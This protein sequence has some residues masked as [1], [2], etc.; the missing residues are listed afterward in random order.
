VVLF[1]AARERRLWLGVGVY[2]VA[3]YSTLG[4]MPQ[5]MNW[6]RSRGLLG[7]L[8]YVALG[9][10]IA[11]AAFSLR[12]LGPRALTA[13]AAA[14]LGYALWMRSQSIVQERLHLFEYG[15]LAVLLRSAL[16]ER[17]RDRKHPRAWRDGAA[18]LLAGAAGW[19]DEGIQYFLPNRVYDLRDVRLNVLSAS[20]AV[21]LLEAVEIATRRDRAAR[22]AG[23]EA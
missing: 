4:L 5:P 11:A 2:L 14:A 7:P 13:L 3:I 18:V 20:A 16:A 21:A 19:I 22:R 9:A 8:T 23:L 17:F 1:H 15:L 10:G 12:D 6:L